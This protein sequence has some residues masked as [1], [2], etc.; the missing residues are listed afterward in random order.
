MLTGFHNRQSAG[1]TKSEQRRR[2]RIVPDL[3]P[4]EGRSLLASIVDLGPLASV[5]GVNS[6]A[7]VAG[8]LTIAHSNG[9][10]FPIFPTYTYQAFFLDNNGV[11]H[12][13]GPQAGYTNSYASAVNDSG[14][15]VGYS[16]DSI[17]ITTPAPEAF[18]YNSSQEKLTDLGTLGGSASVATS[19]SALGRGRRLLDDD[20][21]QP[22][23]FPLDSGERN[24]GPWYSG[25]YIQPGHRDQRLR[26]DRGVHDEP[27]A[28]LGGHHRGLPLARCWKRNQLPTRGGSR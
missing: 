22:G 13:V 17:G 26:S 8:T 21:R 9:G 2:T 10:L 24:H 4:L 14:E 11:S 18:F 20:G 7:E 6:I 15:V 19:V 25:W 3:E 23:C 5:T 1:C 27:S 12:D 28:G 16:Q